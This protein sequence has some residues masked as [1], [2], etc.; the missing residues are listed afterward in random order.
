MKL[1]ITGSGGRIGRALYVRLAREH[2][3]EGLDRSPASTVHHLGE[4]SDAALL[5]RALDGV[6]AVLHV[7]A[8]HAPHVGWA[9]EAEFRRVNVEGTAALVEAARR[10]GV[11]RIVYTS[12]TAVYG[13]AATPDGRAGWVDEALAPEPETVYHRTKLEAEALLREAALAGGPSLRILRMSRCFPEPAPVMAAFRLHRGID[14]RDV[15]A[16]HALALAH[17]GPPHATYV[18]SGATPFVP[19][20]VESLWRDAP[21]VLAERAP[22]LVAAFAARGWPLP[23]RIDR[24]YDASA[25]RRDLGWRPAHDWT[26][27]LAQHDRGSAEV[28]PSL[29]GFTAATE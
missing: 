17:A 14:A 18:L 13:L 4:L 5:A 28:L 9:S 19:G 16:G 8:L 11:R 20:D 23:A 15:A 10:A 27:V 12:S 21:A 1:L 22:A 3:V 2:A 26:E 24:V 29:R 6:D 7:A 25:A